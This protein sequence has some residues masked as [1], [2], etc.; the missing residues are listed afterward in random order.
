MIEHKA[1]QII[2]TFKDLSN[3]NMITGPT[4]PVPIQAG[5]LTFE[6]FEDNE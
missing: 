4:K 6:D 5:M 1:T 2:S 3:S